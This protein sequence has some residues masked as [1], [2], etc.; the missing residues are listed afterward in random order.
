MLEGWWGEDPFKTILEGQQE[1]R[2]VPGSDARWRKSGD[3][4]VMQ[5]YGFEIVLC[6]DGRWFLNDT[7]GG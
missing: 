4:L 2:A 5:L 6:D 7:S 1:L 3:Y